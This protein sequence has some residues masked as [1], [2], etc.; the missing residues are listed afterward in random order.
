MNIN[1]DMQKIQR[2]FVRIARILP[3]KVRF[4]L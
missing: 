3:L 2:A 4:P 1:R